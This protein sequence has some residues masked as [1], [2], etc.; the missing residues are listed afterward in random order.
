MG[1]IDVG[2]TAMGLEMRGDGGA[3]SPPT[4][5]VVDF[6]PDPEVLEKPE[7]RTFTTA[8]KIKI[9]EEADRCT[10]SGQVGALMRREGLYYSYLTTWRRQRQDG[11][12]A[13]LSKKRG[14]KIV[15]AN[16]LAE[17]VE[18]LERENAKLRRELEKATLII[19]VQK[20][21]STLLG[22]PLEMEQ[23]NTA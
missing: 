11:V 7:R 22:M 3:V 23:G 13:S 14:R 20:K 5:V 17:R 6:R 16:P 4:D 15:P 21:V 19:D 12:F 9:L 18:M 8:Y 10:E 2:M 1:V